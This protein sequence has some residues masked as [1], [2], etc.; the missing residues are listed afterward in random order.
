MNSFGNGIVLPFLV[1][2]LHDVRGFGLGIS[3][4]VVA[5]SAAAQ[6]TAGLVAGPLVDRL[7][8]A[9]G[10][11]RRARPAGGRLRRSSRSCAAR[12]RRSC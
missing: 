2:Y 3:G 10:A 11:R 4:L 8:A 1:I 5:V 7:G 12:G 6:L 9:P